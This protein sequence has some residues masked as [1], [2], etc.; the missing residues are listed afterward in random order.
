MNKS[1][2]SVDSFICLGYDSSKFGAEGALIRLYGMEISIRHICKAVL[3]LC[4]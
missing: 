4:W 1:G 2:F 3:Y